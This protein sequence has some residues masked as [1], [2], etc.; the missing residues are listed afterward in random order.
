MSPERL[1]QR[2]P[3]L[4]PEFLAREAAANRE[5]ARRRAE[6]QSCYGAEYPADETEL[7]RLLA[8]CELPAHLVDTWDGAIAEIENRLLYARFQAEAAAAPTTPPPT[9]TNV[10]VWDRETGKLTFNGRLCKQILNLAHAK[11]VCTLLN[12]FQEEG[13]PTRI[14]DPL[15]GALAKRLGD[16]IASLNKKLVGLRFFRDGTG[17]GIRWEIVPE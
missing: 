13:W 14:D 16:T 1:A 8:R 17:K 5:E 6:W 3:L 10:P 9:P 11:N 2:S 7:L 4:S 15:P 12:V